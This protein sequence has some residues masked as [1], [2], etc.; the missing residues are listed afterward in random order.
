MRW[1]TL[2]FALLQVLMISVISVAACRAEADEKIIPLSNHSDQELWYYRREVLAYRIPPQRRVN[3][4]VD[5]VYAGNGPGH[6]ASG[7]VATGTLRVIR[8]GSY[9]SPIHWCTSGLRDGCDP[10]IS[11]QGWGMGLRPVISIPQEAKEPKE[12]TSPGA[13]E[14]PAETDAKRPESTGW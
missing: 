12:P 7:A 6:A 13:P 2:C 11:A 14:A 3:I 5:C 1:R 9:S 8:G 4:P 10:M